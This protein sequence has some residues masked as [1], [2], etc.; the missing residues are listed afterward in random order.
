[1]TT[2]LHHKK[3]FILIVLNYLNIYHIKFILAVDENLRITTCH[4]WCMCSNLDVT[5][6]VN[7]NQVHFVTSNRNLLTIWSSVYKA[8]MSY[9]SFIR[10]L[11]ILSYVCIRFVQCPTTTRRLIDAVVIIQS[12]ECDAI[13]YGFKLCPDSLRTS[14]IGN[15]ESGGQPWW[16]QQT[17]TEKND[18]MS[19]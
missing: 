12:S 17:N 1:M 8:I 3:H 4:I 16:Y 10:H 19:D 5:Y 13:K 6:W 11:K 9:N 15:M 18:L 2:F 7:N 14:N